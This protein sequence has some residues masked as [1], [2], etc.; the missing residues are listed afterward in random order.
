MDG[1][2]RRQQC[3]SPRLPRQPHQRWGWGVL[4][5]GVRSVQWLKQ[6]AA[7]DN[8]HA[9]YFHGCLLA[10]RGKCLPPNTKRAEVLFRLAAE[11]VADKV[12][13]MLGDLYA[14]S[15]LRAADLKAAWFEYRLASSSMVKGA[16]DQLDEQAARVLPKLRKAAE[17]HSKA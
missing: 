15:A 5:D 2:A 6:A 12:W 7:A 8:N 10:R 11:G 3:L 14:G 13:L 9:C 1:C 17:A 4:P 16:N